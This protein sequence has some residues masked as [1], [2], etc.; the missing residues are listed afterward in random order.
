MTSSIVANQWSR[1][2]SLLTAQVETYGVQTNQPRPLL[3]V[4][5]SSLDVGALNLS[6]F[7][8]DG[9]IPLCDQIVYISKK[10]WIKI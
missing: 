9:S 2:R 7:I 5:L 8:V 4:T 3:F 1:H 10:M 6:N